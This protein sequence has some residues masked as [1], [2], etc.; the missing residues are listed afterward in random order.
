L[1]VN[2]EKIK[3]PKQKPKL[4]KNKVVIKLVGRVGF[5]PTKAITLTDLQSAPFGLSGIYPK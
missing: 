4:H 1:I 2:N 5:E 3:N